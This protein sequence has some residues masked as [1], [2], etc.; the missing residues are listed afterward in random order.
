MHQLSD[1]Q[2]I[3]FF[4]CCILQKILYLKDYPGIVAISERVPTVFPN[5]HKV[6][7]LISWKCPA[8]GNFVMQSDNLH[9]WTVRKRQQTVQD[10]KTAVDSYM[11]SLIPN[12][13]IF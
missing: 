5:Y 3:R 11:I 2:H 10:T 7:E 1:K 13:P 6:S 9:Q 12:R 8:S 4:Q